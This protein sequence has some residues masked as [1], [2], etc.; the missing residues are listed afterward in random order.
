MQNLDEWNETI[1]NPVSHLKELKG[2]E[3]ISES[4]VYKIYDIFGRNSLLSML[5]Q[6]GAGPGEIISERL[7][8]K[9]QK[10]EFDIIEA[11]NVLIS[12]LK[13]FYCIK[14]KTIEEDDEKIR[15]TIENHCFLRGIIKRR[16]K[17][18]PGKAFCRINKGYF[19]VALKKLIGDKIRR[20]EINF[21][22][23]DDINDVCLEELCFYKM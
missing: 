18:K 8:E 23:N 15:F 4:F 12:E 21:L 2:L 6:V 11:L 19:E 5:Y 20:I 7:K 9:Y 14:Y 22:H 16:E 13:E 1:K 3:I 10:E 17:L